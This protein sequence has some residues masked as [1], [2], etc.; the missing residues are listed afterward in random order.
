MSENLASKRLVELI[1][2]I[3]ERWDERVRAEVPPAAAAD[4]IILRDKLAEM[5]EVMSKV[6]SDK[7]NPRTAARDLAYITIHG[8]ERADQT[9]YSL[10]ELILECHILQEVV[11]EALEPDHRLD[12]RDRGIIIQ[13][14]NELVRVAAG[15]FVRVQKA[16]QD[17]ADRLAKT[18]RS[19]DEFLAMLGHE[20][21]N[22]LAAISTA[23]FVL[24]EGPSDRAAQRGPLEVAVRQAR[25]MKQMLDDLLDL[26]RVNEG[27][28][29][30]QT[31]P[32]DLVSEV[33]QA[34][35]VAQGL[36]AR[37]KHVVSVSLPADP[38]YVNADPVRFAQCLGNLFAN[39]AKYT[40]LHGRIE[41][42][43]KREAEGAAVRVRDNGVGID[44]A[45]LPVI[46]DLFGQAPRG[47]DRAGGGL[48]IGLTVVRRLI[49]LHGGRVEASSEGLGK[50]SEFV[51]WLPVLDAV[52][53]GDAVASRPERAESLKV[54][55]VEDN[56]DTAQMMASALEILGHHVVVAHDA[57]NAFAAVALDCPDIGLLDIGLP[58]MSGYELAAKLRAGGFCH[59]SMK[60]VAL[61]GYAE[62]APALATAG[63]D[64]HLIKPV[65]PEQL[66]EL[67]ASVAAAK[68][69]AKRPE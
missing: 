29:A 22:P 31:G 56:E 58:G 7:T 1:P 6:L 18:D 10:D 54:L 48:G 2:S 51:M 45:V 53:K 60:L 38:I 35:N 20:L 5:L 43:L 61:T 17:Y 69:E 16:L 68:R 39:A 49:E 67:L 63:F 50:G 26:A 64:S 14:F 46:F 52:D 4:E 40:N 41:V 59:S 33:Q 37:R 62:D 57:P 15:E 42:S 27:K 44:A 13:Y 3:M 66:S 24:Q 30:L 36:F 65:H 21:R 9:K 12:R 47:P 32:V 34:L 19:K 8:R 23:L 11:L 55:V 25:H 28:I